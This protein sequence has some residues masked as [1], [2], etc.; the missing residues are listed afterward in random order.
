MAARDR[1]VDISGRAASLEIDADHPARPATDALAAMIGG[2]INAAAIN[3]EPRR[4]TPG[5][6]TRC[7]TGGIAL[8]SLSGRP[9]PLVQARAL[10]L[11]SGF[12]RFC[13]VM[14]RADLSLAVRA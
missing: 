11:Y 1:P 2:D 4:V 9:R 12:D 7:V 3:R 10:K 14:F 8:P 13:F 5:C 6:E